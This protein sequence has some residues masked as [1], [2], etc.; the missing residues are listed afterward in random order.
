VVVLVFA[1]LVAIGLLAAALGWWQRR[2]GAACLTGIAVLALVWILANYAISINWHDANGFIDCG[3]H[4]T[5]RQGAVG[6]VFWYA[7]IIAGILLVI[8]LVSAI[9]HALRQR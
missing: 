5:A 1:L 4:C 3:L 2:I 6:I 9:I 7:P 8:A